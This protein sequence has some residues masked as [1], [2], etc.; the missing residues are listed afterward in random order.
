MIL[1]ASNN[2]EITLVSVLLNNHFDTRRFSEQK[3]VTSTSK[4]NKIFYNILIISVLFFIF[5]HQ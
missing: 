5:F 4:K 3:R 2:G 1:R